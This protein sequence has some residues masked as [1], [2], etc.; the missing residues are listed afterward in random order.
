MQ[1]LGCFSREN[2]DGSLANVGVR[3]DEMGEREKAGVI[4]C[5]FSEAWSLSTNHFYSFK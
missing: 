2:E 4:D 3:W 5:F 1:M